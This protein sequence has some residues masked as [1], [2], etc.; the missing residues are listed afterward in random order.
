M[1]L[2]KTVNPKFCHHTKKTKTKKINCDGYVNELDYD[3]HLIMHMYTKPSHCT[4]YMHN[5][6][7]LDPNKAGKK[8]R[9]GIQR[10]FQ[11]INRFKP[12]VQELSKEILQA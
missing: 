7:Q 3:N 10:H 1:K 5:F 8:R 4:T 2:A 9:K 11:K 12:T 6:C